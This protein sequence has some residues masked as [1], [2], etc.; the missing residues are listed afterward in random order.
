[1]KRKFK[2]VEAFI[3]FSLIH[4]FSRTMLKQRYKTKKK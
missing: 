4:N 1:M 2:I 3:Y